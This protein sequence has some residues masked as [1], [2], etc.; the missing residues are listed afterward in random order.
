MMYVRSIE[1]VVSQKSSKHSCLA[2]S[3]QFKR[4]FNTQNVS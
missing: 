3:I 4:K 1:A 2:P